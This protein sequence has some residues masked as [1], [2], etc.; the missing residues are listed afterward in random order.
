MKTMWNSDFT[1][2]KILLEHSHAHLL[3][4][5][6]GC[7][8]VTVTVLSS[9]DSLVLSTKTKIFTVWSFVEKVYQPCSRALKPNKQAQDFF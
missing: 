8:H 3:F 6:D 9:C 1:L 4:M 2:N 7:F 5:A